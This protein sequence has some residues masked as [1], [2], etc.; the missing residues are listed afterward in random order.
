MKYR[1]SFLLPFMLVCCMSQNSS[2]SGFV[3]SGLNNVYYEV[4][5]TGEPIVFI[6]GGGVDLH[7]WR[8]QVEALSKDFRVITYDLR[9]QGQSDYQDNSLNDIEDLVAL[10]NE[11]GLNQVNLVGLSLGSIMAVDFVLAYPEKV[12]R[13]ALLSPGL[14]G[15]QET[16]ASYLEPI[17]A[18]GQ[19]FQNGETDKA[20]D[21]IEDFTFYGQG[22]RQLP[23]HMDTAVAYVRNAFGRYVNSGNHMRIPQFAELQPLSRLSE[24]R[25]KVLVIHGDQDCDYIKLNI[26]AFQQNIPDLQLVTLK[27]AAHLLNVEKPEEVNQHLADFF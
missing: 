24:I 4:H 26:E 7:M 3:K 15:V 17:M 19:A 20:I 14:I 27:G 22:L 6:H 13:M 8:P 9:G 23:A 12:K 5:G 16:D 1:L 2:S 11:L 10:L 18:L 21:I 25:S